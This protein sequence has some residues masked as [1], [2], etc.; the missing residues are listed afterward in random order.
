M[1]KYILLFRGINVG[2]R[3]LLPMKDLKTLL[4]GAGYEQIETY[5]QS[6]NVV[7]QS[8]QPP[9]DDIRE[10]MEQEFGF[11]PE[12]IVLDEP[13]L[14]DAINSNPFEADEGKHMHF[15]FLADKP[16]PDQEKLTQLATASEQFLVTD[17]VF[18]LYAPDGIGRS[19]LA[20]KVEACLGVSGTGRN[21]NTV[22]KL[23]D[24]LGDK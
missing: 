9:N 3:N 23:V 2:G 13:L 5:I 11:K 14:M 16:R 17:S 21:L 10:L 18:Y 24:M 19:K 12:L 15:F 4:L 20:A 8:Q 22:N 7:L 6:G 1:K